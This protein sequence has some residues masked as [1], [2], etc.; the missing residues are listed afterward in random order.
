[1]SSQKNY[2]QDII[3]SLVLPIPYS[4]LVHFPHKYRPWRWRR[5]SLCLLLPAFDRCLDLILIQA[6]INAALAERTRVQNSVCWTRSF[7]SR[8]VFNTKPIN[9][10][11]FMGE[12]GW[13]RK[14][15]ANKL[16]FVWHSGKC[17]LWLLGFISSHR[18]PKDLDLQLS[19]DP[20]ILLN[21]LIDCDQRGGRPRLVVHFHNWSIKEKVLSLQ[22]NSWTE[23]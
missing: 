10:Q 21:M 12:A 18:P 13:F 9:A 14:P 19:P 15:G 4:Q 17:W 22:T 6:T 23:N 7:T 16:R 11:I 3:T 2:L 1:M 5:R 20:L 8:P